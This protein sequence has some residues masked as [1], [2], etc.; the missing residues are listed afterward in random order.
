[1]PG[2]DLSPLHRPAEPGP[3]WVASV[4]DGLG[5][6]P[7]EFAAL[8]GVPLRDLRRWEKPATK[9]PPA[10]E[11]LVSLAETHPEIF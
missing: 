7:E 3:E 1:L 5:Y 4:R 11:R 8:L 9:L 10:A 6:T 2:L